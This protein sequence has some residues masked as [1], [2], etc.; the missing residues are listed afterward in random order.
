[1][2]VQRPATRRE[3]G[4]TIFPA[5]SSPTAPA[6]QPTTPPPQTPAIK[7][8]LHSSIPAQRRWPRYGPRP[9]RTRRPHLV[10]STT[11][12]QFRTLTTDGSIASGSTINLDQ[13]RRFT[14][15]TSRHTTRSLLKV[16]A[17]TSTGHPA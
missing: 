3:H 16:T 11:F 14:A 9:T 10:A 7:F 17:H 15:P 4:A 6:S 5:P 1:M 12:N 8:L 13:T 2:R